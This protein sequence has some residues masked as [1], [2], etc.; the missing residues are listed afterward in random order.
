M[1]CVGLKKFYCENLIIHSAE[2]K[3]GKKIGCW[4]L[5]KLYNGTNCTIGG[6]EYESNGDEVKIGIWKEKVFKFGP[7]LFLNYIGLYKIVKKLVIQ[8]LW[9]GEYT[10]LVVDHMITRKRC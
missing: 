9:P 7:D 5:Y 2:Y 8:R 3:N 1:V 10:K 6:G 4:N